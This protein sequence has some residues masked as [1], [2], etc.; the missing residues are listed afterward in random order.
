MSFAVLNTQIATLAVIALFGWVV[1]AVAIFRRKPH[2]TPPQKDASADFDGYENYRL[3][4]TTLERSNILLWWARVTREG[5]IYHWKVK[6]PPKLHDNPIYRLAGE[7][8]RGGLWNDDQAPDHERTKL[9]TVKALD[10]GAPGYQQEFRVVGADGVHWLSEEVLIRP[11]GPNEWNLAGVVVDVTKR[12]EAEEA[13][14]QTEGQIGKIVRGADCL[15]WQAYVTGKPEGVQ[16]WKMFLPESVLYKRIFGRDSL[17]GQNTLWSKEMIPEWD[18]INKASRKAM[19]EGKSDY[20]HEFHVIVGLK[21]FYVHEHVSLDKVGHATWNLVGV[22]VDITK[23]KETEREL[24]RAR[25]AALESSRIKSEF[26]ANM[27]HEIRTPMNGVIGMTGLLMDTELAPVQREFAETIRNSADSLLTI[28]NDILDFSKIEAGKLTFETLD[29]D[30]VEAVEGALDTFAER[31]RFK[32]IELACDLPA[33]LPRRLRGD[34]GRLRQVITNL[35]GNAIKFTER[36]EVVVRV[37]KDNE[38][39]THATISFSIKDT[40]V[41]ISE[42]VQQRLFQAF[43]QADNSTTR[44]FG[45]TGLGLAISKQ[46]VE[47]MGGKIG[48]RSEPGMGSTFWFTARLEKQTGPAQPAPSIYFRDLF[49]LRVLVVDDN[50]T[51]RQILRHQL[52]AW[53]MQKGS[54]ANGFE[55]LD[56]LRTAVTDGKPYDLAL[57]D[58]Q[59]PEMDGMTLA[60][61]IKSDPSISSTRLIILTSMGYMHSQSELKASGVDAYLVKPVKQSRLFDCL[62]NVLGRAAAEHVF[63]APSSDVP[64]AQVQD[65]MAIARQTRIL[66]AEDNIVNQKVAIAQLKGLGFTADAV[67]NGHE[68]LS[69]LKQVPYDIILMDCQMPEMDGYEASRTIRQAERSATNSWK[70]PMHII[71]MTA[72]AMTGDREK[73]LAAGMDDYLSKPVRKAELR[74]A[75]M[76]WLLP[77][78]GA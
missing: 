73:C 48:V 25:D 9:A 12:L 31:A 62:V 29:F 27:S 35:L 17:P 36:G 53:K 38:T 34:P 78:K 23:L 1:A 39:D 4:L 28:I 13:R 71:A 65:D 40:G 15:L 6:T 47:M 72:N 61:A 18:K 77:A 21:T 59:M 56:L 11:A 20:D 32:N 3:L 70:A 7:R 45:G 52:Y 50:A 75:L 2:G 8:E 51:N 33:D 19:I 22:I 41:G 26:L 58:M 54:A 67:A 42:D 44:K 76:K 60:R 69:A 37:A 49:D 57:L 14:K 74:S 46:L 68:V 24:S 10:E 66:L 55:A 63:T 5:S 43:T 64:A 16:D 30:L